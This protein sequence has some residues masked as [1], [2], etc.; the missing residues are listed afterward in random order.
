M[1]ILGG[2]VLPPLQ[3][4]IAD[5]F[6]IQAS[7]IVPMLAFAYIAFY[8]IYGYKAGRTAQAAMPL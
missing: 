8:G 2:A 7:F 3:G 5:N 6:G 4:W 1:A